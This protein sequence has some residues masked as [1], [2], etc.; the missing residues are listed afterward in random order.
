MEDNFWE[1]DMEDKQNYEHM[2]WT[3][4]KDD[5]GRYYD[6][7]HNKFY[8]IKCKEDIE[9]VRMLEERMKPRESLLEK[10]AKERKDW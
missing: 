2:F 8:R 3:F 4:Y 9:M 7:F 6:R 10:I 1:I 5:Q